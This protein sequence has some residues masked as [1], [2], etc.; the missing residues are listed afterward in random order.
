MSVPGFIQQPFP[1]IYLLLVRKLGEDEFEYLS[2]GLSGRESRKILR[3]H[4]NIQVVC[5]EYLE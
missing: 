2:M 1:L 5:A 3:D 4:K